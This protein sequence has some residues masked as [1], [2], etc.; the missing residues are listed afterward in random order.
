MDGLERRGNLDF[1]EMFECAFVFVDGFYLKDGEWLEIGY[2]LA[3]PRGR[4][5]IAYKIRF[6][7]V[8]LRE[9]FHDQ[10]FL[11]VFERRNDDGFGFDLHGAGFKVQGSRCRE[12]D[13]TIGAL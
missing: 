12:K 6:E 5:R 8:G 9:A 2:L 7:P 11:L 4:K 1:L 10:A 13:S 3:G